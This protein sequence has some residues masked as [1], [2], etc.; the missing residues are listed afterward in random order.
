MNPEKW[1][2]PTTAAGSRCKPAFRFAR[3]LPGLLLFTALSPA[4]VPSA[5]ASLV[6]TRVSSDAAGQGSLAV[7][8]YAPSSA[9]RFRYGSADGAPVVV[10]VP[11]GFEPGSLDAQAG[12]FVDQGLVVIT[13]LFPGGIQGPFRSDGTYDDRGDSCHR[14]LRD[15]LRFA[16]GEKADVQGRTLSQLVSGPV[17]KDAVG[18][19]AQ[20]NGGSIAAAAL[21]RYGEQ[22][23][24]LGFLIPWESPT[25]DQVLAA[26]LGAREMDPDL[27]SDADRDGLPANDGANPA[28]RQYGF[29]SCSVDYSRLRFDPAARYQYRGS[30]PFY[31][32]LFYFDNNGNGR[33]DLSA[34]G[35]VQTDVNH[36]GM[37]DADEDYPVPGL[38]AVLPDGSRRAYLSVK[39]A[40]AA[41]SAR[42]ADPWPAHIAAA[43]ETR[44]YW[45]IRNANLYFA[46]LASRQPALAGMSVFSRIDHVQVA[47][48]HPH[49][50]HYLDG[51]RQNRLW[52]R[53]NPDAAYVRS[54]AGSAYPDPVD[55][56][57]NL[58]PAPGEMSSLAEP[59]SRASALL[60]QAA[61]LAEMADR[62]AYRNWSPN[63]TEPI[64]PGV[65]RPL[66]AGYAGATTTTTTQTVSTTTTT[67]TTTTRPGASSTTSSTLPNVSPAP[68]WLT[69]ALNCHDWSDPDR[70]AETLT[71]FL[72]TLDQHRFQGELYLT[73]PL[74]EVLVQKHPALIERLRGA[75]HTISYHVRAPHPALYAPTGSWLEKYSLARYESCRLDMRT[76][77]LDESQPGGYE[78]V[79]RVFG[80]KPVASG[81]STLPP[82]LLREY[83]S[84]LAAR[85]ARVMVF[86]HQTQGQRGWEALAG[87]RSG[88]YPRPADY[89]LA[90]T[91]A[92]GHAAV[93]GD[94]WWNRISSGQI[95]A[96]ELASAFREDFLDQAGFGAHPRFGI[97]VIHENDFYSRGVSWNPIYFSDEAA[98]GRPLNPPY[99][100]SRAGLGIP[101]R[102]AAE[103][104]AIRRAFAALA[105]AAAADAE[106][107]VATSAEVARYGDSLVPAGTFP[108]KA[109]EWFADPGLEENPLLRYPFVSGNLPGD[110]VPVTAVFQVSEKAARSGKKGLW[111]DA[112]RDSSLVLQTRLDL[113][114]GREFTFGASVAASGPGSISFSLI[115]VAWVGGILRPVSREAAV[116][117][118]VFSGSSDWKEVRARAYIQD[119]FDYCLLRIEITGG[120]QYRLDDFTVTSREHMPLAIPLEPRGPVQIGFL[121]HI[122]DVPAL[123]SDTPYYRAKTQVFLDLADLFRRHGAR[124]TIQPELDWVIGAQRS[125]PGLIRR[126]QEQYDVGFSVHTH[127]PQIPNPSEAAVLDYIA[128]R[129]SALEASGSGPVTDLNGNFDMP[130]WSVFARAGILSMTAYKNK[131]TQAGYEGHYFHPWRP[132][133]GNPT[134]DEKA[135]AVDDPFGRVVYLPGDCTQVTKFHSRLMERVLPGLTYALANARPKQSTTW[136][137]IGHVD[138]FADKD[139]ADLATYMASGQYREDLQFYDRLLEEVLDPLVQRGFARWAHP[140]DM[141]EA[142]ESSSAASQP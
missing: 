100:L 111:I 45:E 80:R 6:N 114:K 21:G 104:L 47:T 72:D 30:G 51:F 42:L 118:A 29:P 56:D 112:A 131:N 110:P 39:A 109:E 59:P 142:F 136:Y 7:R 98:G 62:C 66:S 60:L 125:D 88:L 19:L 101:I 96:E 53:L 27:L 81:V 87:V 83:A 16:A 37:V 124:M 135:W 85:G 57:A 120:G 113:D 123:R 77:G 58:N 20:S 52:Y 38:A 26:E 119:N 122:E 31:Q 108:Q 68:R 10:L 14:A 50:H 33:L 2:I 28:Y 49:V 46:A 34:P 8:L 24:P 94:F 32:G 3:L 106:T 140:S 92:R 115:P 134:I 55:N 129:K 23:P 99:D 89:F 84:V 35:T 5:G 1:M 44:A 73:A 90:R 71:F 138:S 128:E 4:Q 79:A 116:A 11:G 43:E 93:Q 64:H 17:R 48:D 102:S 13:F 69:F 82:E 15:V 36:N 54:V 86:E 74:V 127:G 103:Q 67:T 18:I 63:L 95:T 141:R 132:S 121:I 76:G 70:S 75:V 137:F 126:L 22:I 12:P 130:D 65:G 107:R 78:Y 139:G 25:N 61:A 117:P 97:V 133:P 40:E 9:S 91:D 41:A 105:R